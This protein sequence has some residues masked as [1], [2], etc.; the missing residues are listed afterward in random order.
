M[1]FKDAV[2]DAYRREL[3]AHPERKSQ[4]EQ[5][6]ADLTGEKPSASEVEQRKQAR[7]GR[8]VERAV[9]EPGGRRAPANKE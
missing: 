2:V 6:L 5:K 1:A 8:K 3:A 7:T 4:I 9:N